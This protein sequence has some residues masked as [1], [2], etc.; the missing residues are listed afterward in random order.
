MK[1]ALVPLNPTVGRV[2]QNF[3]KILTFIGKAIKQN[4]ALIIFPE[5]AL[6]G[7]PPRDYLYYPSL[8]THQNRCFA[9][10]KT[11]SKKIT[12]VLGG[13][14][15]NP[16]KGLKLRNTA[17][18]FK[19]G[20]QHVYAK[21]LLPN[22]DVFDEFRYFE[23]GE[24]P[25]RI[26]IGGKKFGIT[27]CEDIWARDPALAT[28][29]HK[30]P[31]P[32]YAKYKLDYLINIS[33]SPFELD[34]RDRRRKLLSDVARRLDCHVIYVNQCGGNDDLIFD[35]GA[36]VTNRKGEIILQE[37]EFEERLV[38]FDADQ[39]K[40][41]LKLS[42]PDPNELLKKALVMGIRDYVR[43]SGF[44]QAVI[45]LSGGIDSS[46]VACLA[47]QALGPDN[48]LGVTL[49]SRYSSRGSVRD[50]REL[51][52]NLGITIQEISIEPIHKAF[53]GLFFKM[54]Q[55]KVKDLTRQNIQAR[56]RGNIL[57]AISN[58]TGRLLLNTS[59]KSEM[60]MGYGT[61]YGDMCGA[62]AVI[63]DLT[64]TQTYA[65]AR[66]INSERNVIPQSVF[67]KPPSAELKRRQK[68]MDTLPPYEILDPMVEDFITHH[69]IKK[70]SQNKRYPIE[71]VVQ[72]ILQSEYKRYQVPPG[73]KVTGKAFGS[74]RRIPIAAS[75]QI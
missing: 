59:N 44:S 5:L 65:L 54:F 50:S 17:F 30:D 67:D 9:R 42:K 14:S 36:I 60:A 41:P 7:Y 31:V 3:E 18:I 62:L 49:P 32:E 66:F 15:R 10:L 11:R 25:L 61:L 26:K 63:I 22:Y 53:E 47:T 45:G 34:K 73:L 51:A 12:I 1:I 13:I 29:Y 37:A 71:E 69:E 16:G 21:Q 46:L 23:P 6:I 28:R 58:N 2:D 55:G 43:K 24:R 38:I 70:T 57:M 72:K 48:V 75:L 33:A 20:Q 56:I 52:K 40:V 68:D 64:K 4:C 8:L 19:N 35:G 27:V 74:G 39:H